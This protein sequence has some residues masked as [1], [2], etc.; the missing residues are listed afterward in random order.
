MNERAKLLAR[1]KGRCMEQA[2]MYRVMDAGNRNEAKGRKTYIIQTPDRNRMVHAD[3]I[4]TA[5]GSD[6]VSTSISTPNKG[7]A[8]MVIMGTIPTDE[9]EGT[10]PN[11]TTTSTKHEIPREQKRQQPWSRDAIQEKTG[12]R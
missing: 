10:V 11:E 2:E 6:S 1:R 8:E 9:R 3:D 4:V 5:G 12:C 7:A